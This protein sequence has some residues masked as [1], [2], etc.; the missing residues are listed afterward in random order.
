MAPAA[1]LSVSYELKADLSLY[2]QQRASDE[3]RAKMTFYQRCLTAGGAGVLMGAL[4]HVVVLIAGPDWIAFVGAPP[5]V[6]RSASEGTWLAPVGALGIASLLTV[7]GLYAL[8]GAG[9]IRPLLLLKTVLGG[10]ALLFLLRGAIIVP[11]L[12]RVDWRSPHDLFTV[13]ASAFIFALG[14]SYALGLWGVWRAQLRR[15]LQ[16]RHWR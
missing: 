16:S 6:V 7:W 15:Q 2:P 13:T 8:S 11:F 10:V 1:R 5:V 14:A 3:E 9:W 4:L 12:G